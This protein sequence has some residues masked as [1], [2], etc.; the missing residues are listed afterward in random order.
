MA[1][2]IVFDPLRLKGEVG[3]ILRDL[4]ALLEEFGLLPW[5][6]NSQGSRCQDRKEVVVHV[7]Q[8]NC[9]GGMIDREGNAQPQEQ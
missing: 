3:W 6:E 7:S 5:T 1:R 4:K 2:G 8:G 9:V